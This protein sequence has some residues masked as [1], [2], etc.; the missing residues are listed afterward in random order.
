MLWGPSMSNL[1]LTGANKF[2]KCSIQRTSK[3]ALFFRDSYVT[4]NTANIIPGKEHNFDKK[5]PS[6]ALLHGAY[7]Y[8]SVM[9]YSRCAFSSNNFETITALVG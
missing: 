2:L 3:N 5:N 9:H 8:G 7:D 1:D 4:I 6:D